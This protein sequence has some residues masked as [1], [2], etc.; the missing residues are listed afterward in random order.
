[1]ELGV[2]SH[3]HTHTLIEGMHATPKKGKIP[4]QECTCTSP[5]PQSNMQVSQISSSHIFVYLAYTPIL[6]EEGI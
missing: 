6:R 1:M 3:I 2:P 4:L 5:I